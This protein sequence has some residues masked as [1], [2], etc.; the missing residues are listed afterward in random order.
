M[1][2]ATK[3]K[4]KIEKYLVGEVMDIGCGDESIVPNSFGVDGRVF[5][6]VSHATDN[7]YDLPSQLPN[8]IGSFDCVFS[9]H[10][11]EHL[12]D[13][14]RCINEWSEFVKP[15][16]YFILYLPDGEAYNNYE[17]PE[18]FHD[19]RYEPFIF[20]FKRAFCGEAKNFKG[21]AYS[22]AKFNLLESGQDKGPDK[23][24]FYLV[25]KKL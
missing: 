21:H 15:G 13:S 12:P 1:V 24:S 25:A 7:L 3:I 9:S 17:N 11:L 5:P 23:Y 8:K 22:P 16:G 18:H 2:E 4:H 14:Y 19:T 10:T 6:C 20:W